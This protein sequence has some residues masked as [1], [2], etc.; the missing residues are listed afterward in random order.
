MTGEVELFGLLGVGVGVGMWLVLR[1]VILARQPA[2]EVSSRRPRTA[3]A[4]REHARRW[5]AASGAAGLVV[6]VVTGWV[7][8]GLLTAAAVW[9]GPRLLG[10]Q[11]GEQQAIDRIEAVATWA[12]TL[13]DTLAA[14][15]GLEQTITAT[16]PTAPD[17]VRPHIRELAAR[18]HR[19]QRLAPALRGLADELADPTADLVIAALILASEHQARQLAPRLGALADSARSQVEMRQRVGAARARI[20][21]TV[22]IVVTTTAGFVAGLCLLNRDFLSPYDSLNGQGMLLAIGAVFAAALAWLG[23]LARFEQP[24]R[25]LTR[26]PS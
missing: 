26:S 17:A 20:R 15:A 7:A 24:E 6:A 13:R 19:G 23:R 21:T 8:A 3:R 14:G 1:T 4:R 22:R 2:D 5:L 10:S 18:L 25:F 16:A 12:E 11:H 9:H